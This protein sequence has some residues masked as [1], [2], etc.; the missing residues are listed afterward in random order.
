MISFKPVWCTI[1]VDSCGRDLYSNVTPACA[2]FLIN[3]RL[4]LLWALVVLA[5]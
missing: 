4:L 5:F 3:S 1:L 2:C